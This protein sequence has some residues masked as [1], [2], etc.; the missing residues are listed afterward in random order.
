MPTTDPDA[1]P[2]EPSPSIFNWVL[3][4]L[5]VGMAWGLT[6]P[7]MRRAAANAP[8]ISRPS[9]DD[10]KNSWIK[11]KIL[12]VF[13]GIV[14]TIRRPAYAVPFLLN[15]TGSV[16]FFLLIGKAGMGFLRAKTLHNHMVVQ[17]D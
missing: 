7:F 1:P 17:K 15:V 16:W 5:L 12:S 3:G 10:P 9:V 2:P 13:W 14:D 6:T 11:R 8:T 4:F